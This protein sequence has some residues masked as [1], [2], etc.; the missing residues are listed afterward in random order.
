[1]VIVDTSVWI[2]FFKNKEPYFSELSKL[3]ENNKVL[4]TECIFAE[5][6]QGVNNKTETNIIN[7]FWNNLPK[8]PEENI[9]IKA[10]EESNRSNWINKG[11]GLIDSVIIILAR[12]T[13]SMI[14]TLD[15]KMNSVLKS[16]EIYKI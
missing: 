12:E 5:L 8:Y 10:G 2:E 7:E 9:F 11:I 15:K 16:G 4:A 3:L 6:L 1:M 13:G 14:W